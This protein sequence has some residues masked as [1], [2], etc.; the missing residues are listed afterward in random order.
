MARAG[1]AE[2]PKRRADGPLFSTDNRNRDCK[3]RGGPVKCQ[4]VVL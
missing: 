3:V 4:T 1:G 2:A